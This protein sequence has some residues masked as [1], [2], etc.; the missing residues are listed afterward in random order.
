MGTFHQGKCDLHG[1]TVVVDTAG[2]LVYV[3]RCDDV[4]ESRVILLDAD[5]H[6][7]R[8]GGA[9]KEE[10]LRKAA[11]YGT[12]SKHPRLVVPREV[13]RS[14]RKLGDLPRP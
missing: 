14:V 13:V 7:E 11:L 1:M 9:T 3:G 10:Y 12:W 6:D 4:E 5:V 2:P 8:T